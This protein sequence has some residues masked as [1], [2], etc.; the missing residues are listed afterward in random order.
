[1]IDDEV[2]AGLGRTGK[3]LTVDW[4]NVKPDIVT[5][6]KSLSGGYM[7]VSA[8]LA[9]ENVMKVWD[10]GD[11]MSTY[12]GN[13][14]ALAVAKASVEV[15]FEDKLIENAER[16]GKI[17]DSELRKWNE[18]YDFV[19]DV[20]SGK[21]LFASVKFKDTQTIWAV[22]KIL[23][24]KGV[25]TRPEFGERMHI[26]PPLCIKEEE[27]KEG[28]RIFREALDEIKKSGTNPKG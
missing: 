28:L 5:L 14:L 2:Q 17:L 22:E 1:M 6:G 26:Q 16:L 7:P 18:T 9:N 3:L 13:P 25:I 15:L 23:L 20:Q 12:A 27:L 11:H 19:T 10:Y 24:E 4:E 21:G 8:V